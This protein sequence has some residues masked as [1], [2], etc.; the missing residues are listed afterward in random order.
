M[1]AVNVKTVKSLN[2]TA[3]ILNIREGVTQGD[4]LAIIAKGIGTLPLI[5]NLK[6]AITGVTQPW[7]ADNARALGTFTRLETYFDSLTR[8]VPVRVY[9]PKPTK[10]VLIVRLENLDTLKVFRARHGFRVCT[11]VRYLGVYIGDDDSK[12]DWLR[13][14]TLM[15]EKYVNT[16]SEITWKYPN[17]SYAAV[18]RAIQSEWIFIQC[19]TWYTGD[20]F[21]GVEK[22]IHE[23]FASY[24]FRK[25]ETTLPCSRSSNYND[26][27]E[28]R[29]GTSESSG[30]SSG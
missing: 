22:I 30:V 1:T 7:Y 16:I 19:V 11:G 2:G 10:S 4:T 29:T 15:W 18:V 27:Q 21:A 20:L 24:F 14:C 3:S 6:W 23:F 13:E 5:N 25:N 26:G 9:H 17:E 8:Q 12:R 28:I